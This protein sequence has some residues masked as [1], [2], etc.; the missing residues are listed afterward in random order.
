MTRSIGLPKTSDF[1]EMDRVFDVRLDNSTCGTYQVSVPDPSDPKKTVPQT[2]DFQID[3]TIKSALAAYGAKHTASLE[4]IN[5][6][7][8]Q[9]Y[10]IAGDEDEFDGIRDI[11]FMQAFALGN[12]FV[13]KTESH[14]GAGTYEV[15]LRHWEAAKP[16]TEIFGYGLAVDYVA[17]ALGMSPDRF[18]FMKGNKK[19]ADL[20][21][22]VGPEDMIDTGGKVVALAKSGQK[23]QIEVKTR[24][25]WAGFRKNKYDA[26]VQK[27]IAE[28]A[29]CNPDAIVVGVLIALPRKS[30]A[31]RRTPHIV[32]ADPNSPPPL[33]RDEQL[34]FL[35]RRYFL[36]ARKYGLWLLALD[37]LSWLSDLR[38]PLTREER[39]QFAAL[40]ARYG[41]YRQQPLNKWSVNGRK[42]RG[43]FFCE[44]YRLVGAPGNRHI[45]YEEAERM[46]RE[47]NLGDCYF[48]GVSTLLPRIVKRRRGDILLGLAESQ[49][50][51]HQSVFLEDP[52]ELPPPHRQYLLRQIGTWLR[53]WHERGV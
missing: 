28:K 2:T 19:R 12:V 16:V 26:E 22:T 5:K 47:G 3:P 38:V 13:G 1:Y 53:Q 11:E 6:S 52:I 49:R 8:V 36:L 27:D 37:I 48:G 14:L 29:A 42:Y 39:R 20:E 25:G 21:T 35:L 33:D 17:A 44:L 31:P 41:Q 46:Y 23:L 4:Q 32:V 24:T 30:A 10:R 50:F 45:A 9:F 15:T 7:S 18:T 43:R 40:S 34:D 51:A